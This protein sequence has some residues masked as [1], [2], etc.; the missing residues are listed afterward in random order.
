VGF[1]NNQA[2]G[3][4]RFSGRG[5]KNT[6]AASLSVNSNTCSTVKYYSAVWLWRW[7]L[8]VNLPSPLFKP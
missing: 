6:F 1:E 2:S 3:I 7:S 8:C 4:R 5:R